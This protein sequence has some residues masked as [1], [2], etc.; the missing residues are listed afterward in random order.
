[1]DI[2]PRILI[3]DD[4]E[5]VLDACV[6]ILGERD[7]VLFTAA[8]GAAGLDRLGT[9]HPDLVFVDLKMPGL[10]GFQVLERIREIDPAVV[11][12]VITGYATLSSAVEAMQKGAYD[13]LPKPFA[14]DEF[15]VVTT[16]ALEKRR[17]QQEALRLRRERDLLRE[18]FASIVSHELK[19]PLAAVQ[20]HLMLLA[21]DLSAVLSEVQQRRLERLQGRVADLLGL[22]STW[23][24]AIST[25]LEH[26]RASFGPVD[27]RIVA[28]KA[29]DSVGL[30]ATRK[31]ITLETSVPQ[32]LPLVSGDSGTLV[33]ALVNLL[34]NAVKY[35]HPGGRV[36]LTLSGAD[37]WVTIGVQ[38][39][40]VGIP[41][42][43]LPLISGG[44]YRGAAGTAGE[45][46][47]GLGLAVTRRIVEAHGGT[48]AIESMLGAGSTFT[49]TL[50]AA[51]AEAA[52]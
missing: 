22:I 2:R 45:S 34:G 42:D 50:P 14:P 31:D 23:V 33:E 46:G 7:Y 44:L 49:I 3:I 20:Q 29:L 48:L 36:V 43:E 51:S 38:D 52:A 13:F 35:S 37:R 5:V 12:V 26:L 28:G 25:D 18:Q 8:E 15:R 19:A 10:S 16:R 41:P 39:F 21:H 11:T 30:L 17:L 4:E 1:M 40:G 27:L 6:Q 32:D 24:R 47:S 9:F